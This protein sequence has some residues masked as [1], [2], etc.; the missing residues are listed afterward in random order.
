MIEHFGGSV[1]NAYI[2]IG[3]GSVGVGLFFTLSGVSDYRH[4]AAELRFRPRQGQ[5]PGSATSM[6]GACCG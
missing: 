3:A 2:P 5:R 1:L 6:P 4:P